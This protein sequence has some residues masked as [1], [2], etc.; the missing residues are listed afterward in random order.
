MHAKNPISLENEPK[1]LDP[2]T[3]KGFRV[4]ALKARASVLGHNGILWIRGE[5]CAEQGEEVV[6]LGTE[7]DNSAGVG[8][9]GL[10]TTTE[11]G[12][13]QPTLKLDD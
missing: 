13:S 1:H 12:V 11:Q 3:L 10:K 4:T 2:S 9:P 7:N 8:P 5:G 6:D